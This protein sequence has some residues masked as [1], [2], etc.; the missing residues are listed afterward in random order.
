VE[1]GIFEHMF[2]PTAAQLAPTELVLAIADSQRQES[3]LVARRM[4]DIAELL[5]Q[6]TS[7]VEVEDPDPGFMIVTGFQ[8]TTAEVAAACNLS[9]A[10]VSVMV[11]HAD[12]LVQRL[13][14]VAA[15]LAIGDTDWRTV[16]IVISRTEFVKDSL[17]RA[18][19]AGLAQRISQW[20]CWSRKRVINT[21]DAAVRRI[22]PDAARERKLREDR[23]HCDVIALGDGTAKVDGIVAAQAGA[24]FDTRLAQLASA[25]CRDDPRTV[26]QR[27]SDAMEAMAE[28]R[29]LGCLCGAADCPNRSG[30][31]APTVRI[32]VNVIAS[33]DTVMCGGGRPGY[34]EGYGVIDAEQVRSLAERASV[35]ILD[36]PAV[37]PAEALRYQPTAAVERWVR[38]RDMTCRFPGCDRSAV[39][40]D[41]DHTIPFNHA[42]PRN[43]GL[44]VPWNLKCLCRQH[45]RDK[46]F[47][48]GW[49]DEQLPDGTVVWT[50]P[51]GQ[52]YETSPGGVDLFPDMASSTACR[53]PKPV[54]RNRS[55][56]RAAHIARIRCRNPIQRSINEAHR[57]LQQARHDEIGYRKDRNRMRNMLFLLKG[58]PST[59]PYCTWINDDFEPE[60]LPPDWRPPPDPHPQPDDPPF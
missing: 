53:E 49:R 5:A 33:A 27:R 37:S 19:D 22:D 36:E 57:R 38:M 46:T 8:R 2:D 56:E 24:A 9:P 25:V 26:D 1:P 21:V 55:R 4:A 20:R 59:S 34:I 6:R 29:K 51:T 54:R 3:M 32:V 23:R 47:D 42:D 39:I 11:S 52:V 50:S 44:T 31:T 14:E 41:L 7:E 48:E 12:A 16:Q 58:R 15:L 60:E 13:P 43:G 40:C 17:M 18:L 35:R 28:G 30:D 45:H 10:A